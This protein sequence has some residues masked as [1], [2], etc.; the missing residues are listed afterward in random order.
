MKVEEKLEEKDEDEA[1]HVEPDKGER[2]Q[3]VPQ[4]QRTHV[5]AQGSPSNKTQKKDTRAEPE[6]RVTQR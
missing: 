1:E 3:V 5:K 2:E 6:E 4:R